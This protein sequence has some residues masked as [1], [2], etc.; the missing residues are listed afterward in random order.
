M[1]KITDHPQGAPGWTGATGAT[2]SGRL[3]NAAASLTAIEALLRAQHQRE[4]G[5]PS[6]SQPTGWW[7]LLAA[8]FVFCAT[9]PSVVIFLYSIDHRLAV[10]ND[11]PK[12]QRVEMV[13]HPIE[14][15]PAGDRLCVIP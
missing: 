11:H 7:L 4:S 10:L 5:R 12:P 3:A 1:S 6:R 13:C 2:D 8:V 9:M 15:A 14:D